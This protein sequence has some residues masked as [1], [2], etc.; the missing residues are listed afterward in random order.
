MGIEAKRVKQA[1]RVADA[2]KVRLG[3]DRFCRFCRSY[4][5]S[6]DQKN[7]E[8]WTAQ[9]DLQPI[10]HESG[11]LPS[12]SYSTSRSI[13]SIELWRTSLPLTM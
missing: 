11:R 3:T 12:G 10:H 4:S 9:A 6:I 1:S 13:S 8:I 2:R 7:G 5:Y